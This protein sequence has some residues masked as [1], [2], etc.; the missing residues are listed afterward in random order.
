LHEPETVDSETS[1]RKYNSR[2][3]NGREKSV[4]LLDKDTHDML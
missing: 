4:I 3:A 1:E 2:S